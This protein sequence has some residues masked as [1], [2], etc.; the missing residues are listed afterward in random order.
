M[1]TYIL[2]IVFLK[3]KKSLIGL[4]MVTK[5]DNEKLIRKILQFKIRIYLIA[6]LFDRVASRS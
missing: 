2:K 6:Y 3:E 4:I 1:K 5:N